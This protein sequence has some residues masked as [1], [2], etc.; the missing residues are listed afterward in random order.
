MPLKLIYFSLSFFQ[1][2]DKYADY[3]GFPH[4]E[5]WRKQLCLSALVNSDVNLETYRDSWDDD[6]LLQ[7]ALLSP[8]FTQFQPWSFL[9]QNLF[10]IIIF[11]FFSYLFNQSKFW[12]IYK[13][14]DRERWQ[15]FLFGS[16]PKFCI[17]WVN[18]L[19]AF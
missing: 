5:E 2:C 12:V 15:E 18:I 14:K 7:Q 6:D 3:S 17:A 16:V 19:F 13:P 4:L 8:H 11:F 1:Y 10:S 9:I